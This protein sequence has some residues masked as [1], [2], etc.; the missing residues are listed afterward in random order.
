VAKQPTLILALVLLTASHCW[1]ATRIAFLPS[2]SDFEKQSPMRAAL[3]A[4]DARLQAELLTGWDSEV[5]S[6]AGLSAVVFEQKLR[7][8]D[9]A[10]ASA[11]RVLPSGFLVLS[12]LDQPKNELRVFVNRVG[13]GMGMELGAPKIF[14]IRN[15]GDIANGLPGEVARHVASVAGLAPRSPAVPSKDLQGK[16]LICSL[17][18]PVSAGGAQADLSQISPLI[19]AV[20]EDVVAGD[21]TGAT[22]V[23]RSETAKLLDEKALTATN[24]LNAN[25]S[26]NLGRMAKADL[27]LIP[28]IH[29]QDSRKIG[30]DL[31]AVDVASGR[32]LA[33]RSWSGALLDAPPAGVVRELL[34]EG[35]QAAGESIA[36][37][38]ADDPALRHAEAGFIIG[39]KEG[40]AGLRQLVA[41]EA[42][43]S[44][45]LGD[46]SLAL[47]SD[48]PAIMRKSA[49][50]F[51]RGA[52]PGALYPLQL[53]YNPTDDRLQQIRELKKSGQLDLIHQQARQIFELPMTELAK[54]NA[55]RDLQLLGELWI[56]LGDA[57]KG[58]S[59][60][61][62]GGQPIGELA[63]KSPFYQSLVVALMNLGRYQECVALLERRGNWSSMCTPIILDAYRALNNTKRE[64]QLMRGNPA[65]T[66]K[67]ERMTARFLDLSRDLGES[68]PAIGNVVET[69]NAWVINSPLVRMAMIRARISAGQKDFAIADAQCALIAATKAKDPAAQKE[70]TAILSD[71][72][73]KPLASLPAAR[74]FLTIP[75]D[76]RIDLIHDQTVDPKYVGEVAAHV[77][78]FW[79]CDVHV[80][81]IRLDVSKFSSYRNLSQALD[82]N[83]FADTIARMELPAGPALGTVMLTQT[84]LISM[85]KNYAGDIYSVDRGALTIL[86]DHYFRKFKSNDP[87]PLPLITA[88]AVAKLSRVSKKILDD[89]KEQGSWKNVFCPPPPDLF[90]SNGT[91]HLVAF[92]LGISP[93][94][95]AH[96]KN[97]SASDLL[98][99]IPK[100]HQ[101]ARTKA[102]DPADEPLILDLA[103]QISQARPI[104]IT[105]QLP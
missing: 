11:L 66:C 14:P 88:I 10:S 64:F 35:L 89:S 46:A 51:Y 71:L 79:G 100:T 80:R 7:A 19:R 85:Q 97:V 50:T 90:A 9:N 104:I 93:G 4:F 52:T 77:A 43:L 65:S 49:A 28:F 2:F 24:G 73:A 102:P 99:F 69:A 39:L 41:T 74:E 36:R 63:A 3:P 59:I 78:H 40:W 60:L 76:C 30:T 33:C 13:I 75:A 95:G 103:N 86:S 6:R 31:F 5:L 26:T 17:L 67:T 82:G 105:P 56:R 37:P 48:E 20:L 91:L 84:K 101:T 12:V 34:R 22:L 58:W 18:E 72:G 53:E 23:E 57:E 62:R 32:M 15:P 45:R 29:F 61:N 21:D 55:D 81:S 44:I 94:T 54:D 47:A 87:R 96:L 92:D 16:P 27:I 8:T 83:V 98:N 70:I 68:G 1:A 38:V 25:G 42:E